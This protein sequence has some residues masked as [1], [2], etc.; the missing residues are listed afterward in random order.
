MKEYVG[1]NIYELERIAL[2]IAE[3]IANDESPEEE[4]LTEEEG[5]MLLNRV[6][7]L[8]RQDLEGDDLK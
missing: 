3:K 1:R 5:A 4:H 2:R 6:C 8:I 7:E